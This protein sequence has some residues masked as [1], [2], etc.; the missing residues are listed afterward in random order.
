MRLLTFSTTALALT[1]CLASAQTY[2]ISTIL[3]GALPVDIPGTSAHLQDARAVALDSSGNVFFATEN[4]VLRLDVATGILSLVAGNGTRGFSGDGGPATAAQLHLPQSLALDTDGNI[5]IADSGNERIRKVTTDGT[6]ATVAGDGVRGFS[7]DGGPAT[8]ARLSYPRG[9]AVDASGN[10]YIVDGFNFRVRVVRE[11]VISTFAGTG[12]QGFSGDGGLA[13]VA[14]LNPQAIGLDQAGALLVAESSNFGDTRIRR[15][16]NG[17]ITTVAGTGA[18]GFSGD[19]GPALSAQ[20]NSPSCVHVDSAGD[21][22]VCDNARIRKV[23]QGVITTI[24]GNGGLINP[25]EDQPA[26][27][28][29]VQSQSLAVDSVGNIYFADSYY[30]RVRRIINGRITTVAGG[31]SASTHQIEPVAVAVG[32]N[33]NLY[34][35][36]SGRRRILEWNDGEIRTIAGNGGRPGLFGTL[37]G[38]NGPAIEAQ[39]GSLSRLATD[40]Q[41]NLYIVD[42]Q[43]VR[44]ISEG[45][46]ATVAGNGGF[47]ISGDNGPAIQASTTPG[48]IAV[49]SAGNLYIVGDDRLR[50]VSNGVITTVAGGGTTLGD[51]GPATSA[52]L[53][54]PTGVAVD[55]NDNVFIADSSNDR[56]RRVST[57]GIITT[58]AGGGASLEDGVAAISARLQRPRD[59]AVDLDGNVYFVEGSGTQVIRKVSKDGTIRTIAGGGTAFGDDGPATNAQFTGSIRIAV[60]AKGNIYVADQA[61]YRVR[62]LQ[63]EQ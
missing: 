23:S 32:P 62:L 29:N 30:G 40:S 35:A 34:I 53:D 57:E 45:S 51:Q 27:S 56:I 38:D 52:Q 13:I 28:V 25:A 7:G 18:R 42:T 59:V 17:I 26:T 46:I 4:V 43:R 36:D 21:I 11:G 16:A 5:Y 15:I 9:I 12:A 37:S 2:R 24:A 22:Y 48:G 39:F 3:G 14:S 47:G 49:D 1:L 33:R 8:R 60:D 50:K 31:G 58:V 63:P 19:G 41:N 10:L 54:F 20:F 55:S 44:R 61:N 6:I